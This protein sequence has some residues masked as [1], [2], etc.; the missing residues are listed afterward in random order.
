MPASAPGASRTANPI[1]PAASAPLSEWLQVMWAQIL[2]QREAAR[3]SALDK[4]TT[5]RTP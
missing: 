4:D 5:D 1:A 2:Q 3:L